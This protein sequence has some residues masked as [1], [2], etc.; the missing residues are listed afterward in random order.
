MSIEERMNISNNSNL[1]EYLKHSAFY[2]ILLHPEG[3]NIAPHNDNMSG[4]FSK[5]GGYSCI[6][7]VEL[8]NP[9][10]T[11]V[12][13]GLFDRCFEK[14][15]KLRVNEPGFRGGWCKNHDFGSFTSTLTYTDDELII[16]TNLSVKRMKE[17]IDKD[18][19]ELTDNFFVGLSPENPIQMEYNEYFIKINNGTKLLHF[20]DL[21]DNYELFTIPARWNFEAGLELLGSS[22][23]FMEDDDMKSLEWAEIKT[24]MDSKREEKGFQKKK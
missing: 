12:S 7:S 24:I 16:K 18:H 6:K 22:E 2:S 1:K 21:C 3:L 14:G 8:F 9:D 19:W 20:S 13:S 15:D 11:F 10:Y 23:V 4:N 5:Q 17:G